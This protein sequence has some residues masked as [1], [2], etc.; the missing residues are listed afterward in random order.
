M[1]NP[2]NKSTRIVMMGVF[3]LITATG[4]MFKLS[5]FADKPP[6]ILELKESRAADVSI[7]VE[8]I[9]L[10]KADIQSLRQ[11]N[12]IGQKLAERIVRNREDNGPFESLEDLARVKG[13]SL[14]LINENRDR[15]SL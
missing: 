14:R 3:V 6:N 11:L 8:R 12:G 5:A 10:N 1:K 7:I 13:V 2:I 4:L 9:S 15:L